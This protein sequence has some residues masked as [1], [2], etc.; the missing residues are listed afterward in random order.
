MSADLPNVT[1]LTEY[2]YPEEASTA[3]LLTSLAS[4]LTER[5]HVS[6]L[7]A[8][9]NYH[10]EDRETS[11]PL[12]ERYQDVTIRRTRAT[13][14]NKDRLPLR[15]LNWLSFTTLVLLRLLASFRDDNVRVVLSNP[16]L[17]PF[18][19][20]IAKRIQG[21][22]YIYVVYDVYPEMPIQLGYLDE[23][24]IVARIWHRLMQAIYRDADRIVVL[25][26]SMERHLIEKMDDDPRFDPEK[27][28]VIPNWE[29][30]SF[31]EPKSKYENDFATEHGTDERFTLLY[32]GNIG[33]F[34][35]LKT[36]IDAIGELENRGRT[37][38]QLIIIGEGA[39]K[40]DLETYVNA[41]DI[42]NVKF[43]PFQPMDRL[44][45]T[46]TAG[47][48]SLVGIKPEMEGLCVSSKLYSS[49]AAG[50]PVLAVVGEGDEVARV[51]REY[52]CGTWIRPSD[53]ETAADVLSNWADDPE[54]ATALG[55]NARQSLQQQFS[56]DQ[57]VDAYEEVL[58]DLV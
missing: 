9:P 44:P 35:E 24:G 10:A 5:F 51:V 26:E 58:E 17:L 27:I 47:D 49:L 52:D 53:V 15:L 3:Q 33:R 42:N 34:H 28:V 19:T 40:S 18:A 2:F 23:D 43:L 29:D 11:P 54:L 45:E 22:P 38:I 20:W 39:K 4:G 32:S 25:G 55:D 7:T 41:N 46:L 56:Q 50:M 31:I 1:L 6:A 57:A 14:F 48:A 13:R 36:A 21:V 8:L 37:D 16:P 30:Q 12:F